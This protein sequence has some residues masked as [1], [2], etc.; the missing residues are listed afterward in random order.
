MFE[1]MLGLKLAAIILA[2][3]GLAGL[4]FRLSYEAAWKDGFEEGY[5]AGQSKGRS[6]AMFERAKTIV[7]VRSN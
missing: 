6:D 4:M 2:S 5:R 1:V 3:V 7:D